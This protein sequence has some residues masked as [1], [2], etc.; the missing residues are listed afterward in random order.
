MKK[1]LSVFLA[2]YFLCLSGCASA[3][4]VSGS[5][6]ADPGSASQIVVS[7]ADDTSSVSLREEAA[8][9]RSQDHAEDSSDLQTVSVAPPTASMP[10]TAVQT[11][12]KVSSSSA[13]APLPDPAWNA[14][15]APASNTPAAPEPAPVV[16]VPKPEP[17]PASPP[18]P[19]VDIGALIGDAHS[20]AYSK[21]MGVN[22][23]LSIGNA[24]FDNPIDTSILSADAI[25][26]DLYY[27]IDQIAGL[28][29]ATDL[30]HPPVYNIVQDGSRIYVLYG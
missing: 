18:A 8:N 2:L 1:T 21:N 10:A 23:S 22:S 5:V 28:M 3:E 4:P 24:G 29:G 19:S 12:Q 7:D 17:A 14:E 27:C 9:S 20:Y 11:Q 16:P 26:S 6:S 30:D 15:P 25:R 13:P